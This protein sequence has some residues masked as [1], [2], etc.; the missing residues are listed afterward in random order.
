MPLDHS[1]KEEYIYAYIVYTVSRYQILYLDHAHTKIVYKLSASPSDSKKYVERI[2]TKEI[3]KKHVILPSFFA[4]LF[5]SGI[6]CLGILLD[7][8]TN[9]NS[10]LFNS[11]FRFSVQYNLLE[12]SMG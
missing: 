8:F 3:T 4:Y 9:L 10:Y 1:S 2:P 12:Y 11:Y 5:D 6:Q 7:L